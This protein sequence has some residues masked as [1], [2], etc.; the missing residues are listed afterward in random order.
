[1]PPDL[2]LQRRCSSH[3]GLSIEEAERRLAQ[4]GTNRLVERPPRPAWLKL[5]DQFKSMLIVILLIT[6]GLALLIGD[7]KDM[8]VI[9]LVI[10]FS[11]VLGFYY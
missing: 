7:V 1:M 9:L 10:V 6:A 4:Y 2:P 11:A 5:A 3:H 8:V